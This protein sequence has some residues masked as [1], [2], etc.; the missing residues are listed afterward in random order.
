MTKPPSPI[1]D[2]HHLEALAAR[3]ERA[4]GMGGPAKVNKAHAPGKL[5]VRERIE[6]ALDPG[7][8]RE[9]GLLTHSDLLEAREKTPADGKVCGFGRIDGRTVY[10]SGDD[11]TVLAGSGGRVGVKKDH[12]AMSYAARKGYPCIALGEAGGARIPDIMGAT[13]MMSIVFPI[14]GAPPGG[15]A[16]PPPALLRR[17]PR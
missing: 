10:V 13:G 6:R 16:A 11:V 12:D 5:T 2:P 9:V 17:R 14:G 3:R 1:P 15:T 7:T 4:L 8:F